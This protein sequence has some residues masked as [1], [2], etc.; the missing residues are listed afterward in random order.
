MIASVGLDIVEIARI[1]KD[2]K[3]FG[4][5][6]VERILGEK[7]LAMFEKRQDKT[8]F[9]AGR[10]AAKEAIVKALGRYLTDRP[11]LQHLQIIN[12]DSGQ[13][14]LE[15]PSDV[16]ANLEGARCHLSITH[17]RNYAAA[18]AVFEDPS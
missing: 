17:E 1:E 14:R 4:L 18:V 11:P 13:P 16:E 8:L 6:F 2:V 7:E 5:R 9:L 10:F 3:R 12:D 15:M